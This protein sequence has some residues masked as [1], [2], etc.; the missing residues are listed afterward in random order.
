MPTRPPVLL[1]RRKSAAAGPRRHHRQ[2]KRAA[3]PSAQPRGDDESGRRAEAARAQSVTVS[4][5]VHRYVE[6]LAQLLCAIFTRSVH[7]LSTSI[8]RKSLTFVK[9]GPGVSRSPSGVKKAGRIVVGKKRGRIE[10]ERAGAAQRCV[11]ST[12]APRPGRRPSRRRHRCRRCRRQARRI[13][14]RAVERERQRQRIFLVRAAA[15]LAAD[16]DGEFAARQDHGAAALRLQAR[17]RAAPARPRP[18]RASPS[19]SVAEENAFVAGGPD[20]CLRRRRTHRPGARPDGI[21]RVAKIGSPGFGD[22]FAGSLSARCTLSGRSS[23]KRATTARAS[24]S[25]VGSGTV[26]PEPMTVGIVARHV[27]DRER[28]E[29]RRSGAR[30]RAVRP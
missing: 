5:S 30:A 6:T 21:A 3:A 12:Q 1:Q 22:S 28:D 7:G 18:S 27:G 9:V 4:D 26:G 24:A 13:P 25:V 29:A 10:A 15:A 23:L 20:G 16:G 2:R 17:A 11:P 14:V 19:R 8:A